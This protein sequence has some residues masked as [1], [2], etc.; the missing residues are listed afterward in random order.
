MKKYGLKGG[1]KKTETLVTILEEHFASLGKSSSQ[2]VEDIERDELMNEFGGDGNEAGED[3]NENE[4]GE[5]V[6]EEVQEVQVAV[7]AAAQGGHFR[8]SE[9]Q[10][11]KG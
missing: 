8:R 7:E 4:G 5:I 3:D 9:V 11:E 2:S 6:E 1:S 10:L